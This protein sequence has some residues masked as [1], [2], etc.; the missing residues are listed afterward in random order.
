MGF[1]GKAREKVRDKTRNRICA[2]L[3]RLGVDAQMATRGRCEEKVRSA[4]FNFFVALFGT[5]M[6][7]LGIIDIPD[8]LIRWVNV[9]K[10]MA[11]SQYGVS[12]PSY[13]IDCG[14]PDFRLNPNFK[15]RIKSVHFKHFSLWR[16]EKVD[17]RW[18]G[19]D[20]GSGIIR[21]LDSDI[22]IKQ[23]IMMSDSDLTIHANGDRRCWIISTEFHDILSRELW[24]CYQTIAKHLI[25]E[26]APR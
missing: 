7:S 5:S 13:Y 11:V 18:K 8:S 23:A 9:R 15:L 20:S 14:V 19:K 4:F 26:W 3:Q 22:S 6:E 16:K 21:R 1:F 25:T 24:N 10:S 17:L 12:Q 2:D